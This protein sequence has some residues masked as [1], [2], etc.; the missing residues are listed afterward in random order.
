[1]T[2]KSRRLLE[3]DIIPAVIQFLAERGLTLSEEQSQIVYSRWIDVPRPN[4]SQA[5]QHVT[6]HA[7]QR[8]SPRPFAQGGNA[9][10][11]IRECSGGSPDEEGEPNASG[12]GKLPQTC[13]GL[14]GIQPWGY[15]GV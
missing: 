13:G 5:R 8:G 7:V 12:M 15:I 10:S 2:A 1:M 6:Q 3:K 9:H 4:L 14:G 11:S